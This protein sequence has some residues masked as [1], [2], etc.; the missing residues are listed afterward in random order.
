[1]RDD[2][3]SARSVGAAGPDGLG[4][5]AGVGRSASLGHNPIM[6][7]VIGLQNSG[8]TRFV[9]SILRLLTARG[10]SAAVLKH[11]GHSDTAMANDW[12][13]P[14]SDTMLSLAAGASMTMVT[15]GKESLLHVKSDSD[16]GDVDA[17]SRRMCLLADQCGKPLDVIIVEGF[18]KSELPKVFICRTA[19]HISWLKE[20]AIQHLRAVI[21]PGELRN[22]ADREWPMFVETEVTEVLQACDVQI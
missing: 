6:F 9:L 7:S 21:V 10:I 2:A 19:D 17:L 3:R 5:S 1:M 20:H 11:D 8:K 18:K 4:Q 16:A 13:K 14:G 22:Q 15:G 12:E